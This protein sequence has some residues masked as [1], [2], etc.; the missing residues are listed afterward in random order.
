MLFSPHDSTAPNRVVNK[1]PVPA[2]QRSLV[3]LTIVLREQKKFMF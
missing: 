2:M 1:L 3:A